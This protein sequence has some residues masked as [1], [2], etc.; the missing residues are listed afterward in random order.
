MGEPE[1]RS[2]RELEDGSATESTS[3][4][5]VRV[6]TRLEGGGSPERG[7]LGMFGALDEAN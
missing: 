7:L 1:G 3:S 5:I 4:S 6:R 2:V